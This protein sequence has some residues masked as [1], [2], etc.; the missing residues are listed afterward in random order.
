MF[1]RILTFNRYFDVFCESL[2]VTFQFVFWLENPR[3]LGSY[4]TH[5]PYITRLFPGKVQIK[6]NF[7]L[8]LFLRKSAPKYESNV[9]STNQMVINRSTVSQKRAR[10]STSDAD[11]PSFHFVF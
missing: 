2:Q 9:Q 8:F 1:Y 10:A 7:L 4:L 3:L 11:D 5:I 6:C